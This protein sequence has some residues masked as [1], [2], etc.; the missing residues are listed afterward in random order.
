MTGA[1][2]P[3]PQALDAPVCELGEG[4]GYDPATDT[5]WWLDIVGR[6]LYEHEFATGTTRGHALPRMASLIVPVDARR[7][8][9]AME[10]GLYW[11]DR[12]TGALEPLCAIEAENAATRSN[13]GR[14]HPS[15]ALW[16]GT[17]GKRAE[18]GAGAVY[19]HSGN[20]LHRIVER[21]SIPN[22]TCFS[23]DGVWAYL[24][25]SPERVVYRFRCDPETGLPEG[26]PEPWYRHEG[27]GTPDGAVMD[28][29]GVLHVAIWDGAR[30]ERIAPDGR[31][32]DP[33]P[34]PVSRPTCPVF[35]GTRADGLAV[36]SAWE[37][38]DAARRAAEPEAGRTLGFAAGFAGRHDPAFRPG[39][40]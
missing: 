37:G 14:V 33:V 4:P 40:G 17:M 31:R 7:Q 5:L 20:V 8:V 13:D 22:A 19:V 38:L 18:K 6:R 29:G 25:D 28:A 11:R 15:G 34:L 26:P 9:M 39:S 23:A 21:I 1:G 36:T 10:D 27:A 24:A 12:A 3:T 30:I 35:T 16:I 2:I 32:L